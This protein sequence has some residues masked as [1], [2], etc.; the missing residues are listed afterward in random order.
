MNG[1]WKWSSTGEP[2]TG[3]TTDDGWADNEPNGSGACMQFYR[4]YFSFDDTG[5]DRTLEY[6]C[7]KDLH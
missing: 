2:L 6:V 3:T 4:N 1:T 5:C 7:E